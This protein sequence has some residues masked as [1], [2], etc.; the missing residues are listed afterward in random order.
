L[1]C[2]LI[3]ITSKSTTSND[4]IKKYEIILIQ[5]LKTLNSAY[6]EL[7][8]RCEQIIA[9]SFSVDSN[10]EILREHLRVRATYL[11]GNC[12]EKRMRSFLKG[13]IEKSNENKAWLESIIM[14]IADKP[15]YTWTD[16]DA[17]VF[18]AKANDFARRFINL[19][20]LY[21]ELESIPG[22]GFEARR[23]IVTKPDGTEENRI[24]WT[25]NSKLKHLKVLV[26]EIVSKYDLDKNTNDFQSIIAGL[27]E[28]YLFKSEDEEE[29]E[30]NDRKVAINE[31]SDKTHIG[32]IWGKG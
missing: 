26:E 28:R 22:K 4:I 13:A 31:I 20:V 23:V 25:D 21:K 24:L 7:L 27:L 10:I 5:S 9:R 14:I 15:A 6:D 32:L 17:S 12:I 29:D 18:E 3:P 30:A 16:D 8:N 11:V 2:G 19:E 1:A